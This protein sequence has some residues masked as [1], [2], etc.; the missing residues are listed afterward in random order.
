MLPDQDVISTLYGH[1]IKIEDG[2]VY[3]LNERKIRGW[4]RRHGKK[5]KIGP[6]WVEKHAKILHY[7]GRNKPWNEKYRGIL[8]PYYDRY[9]VK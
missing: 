5:G 6:E 7:I 8:K 4:N 3:N 2:Y 9:R 1:K